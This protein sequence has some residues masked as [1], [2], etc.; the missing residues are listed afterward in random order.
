MKYKIFFWI[1]LCIGIFIR[2]YH[3][4]SAPFVYV[5]RDNCTIWLMAKHILEGNMPLFFYGQYYLGPLEA[6]TTALYFL[7]F[8]INVYTLNLGTISYSAI[9]ILSSYFLGKELKDRTLGLMVML[10]AALP[11]W[12]FFYESIAPLGYHIEI[13]LLGNLIFLLVLKMPHIES[14]L[15]R[16]VYYVMLGSCTGIG[17]WTHY[18]ILYYLIPAFIYMIVNEKWINILKN[19]IYFMASCF[20]IAFPFWMFSFKYNFVTFSFPKSKGLSISLK[21]FEELK[22]YILYMFNIDFYSPNM[23]YFKLIMLILYFTAVVYFIYSSV[24]TRRFFLNK[25]SI[26][27]Y[28]FLSIILLYVGYKANRAAGFGY[29][30]LLPVFTFM[31]ISLAYSCNSIS[32]RNRVLGISFFIYIIG[33]NVYDLFDYISVSRIKSKINRE[34]I[35]NKIAYYKRNKLYNFIGFEPKFRPLIFFSNEEIAA[36]GYTEYQCN[37]Y[38]DIVEAGNHVAFS[39]SDNHLKEMLDNICKSYNCLGD[40]RYNFRPHPYEVGVISPG[41]WNAWAGSNSSYAEYAYDRNYDNYWTNSDKDMNLEYIID[42]G[43]VYKI[44]KLGISDFRGDGPSDFKIQ[45]SIDNRLWLDVVNIKDPQPLFWSGPRLYWHYVDGRYEYYFQPVDAQFIRLISCGKI[46]EP[47]LINEVFLYEYIGDREFKIKDYVK[48]AHDIV[49][50]LT[51]RNTK[52]VYADFWMSANVRKISNGRIEALVPYNSFLPPRKN[53]ARDIHIDNETVFVIQKENI[54]ELEV[55]LHE[56]EL[57]FKKKEFN[58]YICYYFL[59]IPEEFKSIPSLQWIGIGVARYSVKELE[60]W[61][62]KWA[63]IMDEKNNLV[64]ADVYYQGA[65]RYFCGN[66]RVYLDALNFYKKSLNVQK[67]RKTEKIIKS[68]FTPTFRCS[69]DFGNGIKFIGWSY[70]DLKITGRNIFIMNYYWNIEHSFRE[71]IFVFVYFLKNGK[72]VFQNDHRLLDKYIDSSI[73]LSGGIWKESCMLRLP[74]DIQGG[75]YI[76]KIGL[77][78]PSKNNKRIRVKGTESTSVE[79]GKITL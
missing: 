58:R 20:I 50:F 66:I 61:C 1:I 51:N 35:Y 28:L 65:L 25:R 7:I 60:E 33:F 73:A 17:I 44:C 32:K 15:K 13:L 56:F 38:A 24:L 57:L 23:N 78:L 39:D 55:I 77:W 74:E 3:I 31:G 72:I 26:N 14:T 12:Y 22:D 52:F 40:F 6:L 30:Y 9:F 63:R 45:V 75:E 59:S 42:M 64:R 34:E 70:V 19:S 71:R 67:Y 62:Y 18:I 36:M 68:K 49:R 21:Y 47:W 41:G 37:K 46:I 54:S 8:G 5:H 76:I 29:N 2:I 53:M 11:S 79:I 69:V 27:V 48:D 10:Y 43:K 16:A 4:W